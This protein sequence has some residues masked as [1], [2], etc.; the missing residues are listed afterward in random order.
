MHLSEMR[1]KDIEELTKMAEEA[2]IENP[3]NLTKHELIFALLT[4][5]AKD[6]IEI[7]GDGVL[8]ILPDGFGFL[9]S[10]SYNYLPG[11]DDIYVSP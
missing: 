4:K 9:R 11:A 1:E 10:P 3:A 6:N 5:K 2:Q 7:F 8:E